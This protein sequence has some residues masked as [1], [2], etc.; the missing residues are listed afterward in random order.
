M[1]NF[2]ERVQFR[3]LLPERLQQFLMPY[4]S[5]IPSG[6][7]KSRQLNWT[8]GDIL[9]LIRRRLIAFSADQ[10]APIIS[11][12]QLCVPKNEFAATIDIEIAKTSHGNPR[13]ALWL[14]NR[15]I[16]E[17]CLVSPPG[18]LIGEEAWLRVQSDWWS[19]YRNKFNETKGST[20]GFWLYGR[21]VYFMDHSIDVSARSERLLL[22]LVQAEGGVCSHEELIISGWED[23]DP[24]AVSMGALRQAM[25]RLKLEI[26][27]ELIKIEIHETD[28]IETVRSKGYRLRK[29]TD[30]RAYQRRP[31]S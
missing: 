2:D 26:E 28:W 6:R 30:G 8:E 24:E 21:D 1:P 14:A 27:D 29:P 25:Q 22:R 13:A 17:H 9:D 15:L 5:L 12:G 3:F 11:L 7:L 18:R 4:L 10:R 20:E 23:E 16:Q 31:K 19:D